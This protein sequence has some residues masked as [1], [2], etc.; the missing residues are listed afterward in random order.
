MSKEVILTI[1]NVRIK[2]YDN[3]NIVIERYEPVYNP[4]TKETN[5]KWRF[6]GYSDTFLKALKYIS[7]KELLIDF[8]AVS[9]LKSYLKQVQESNEKLLKLAEVEHD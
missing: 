1:D 4:T 3:L 7:N 9:D 6:K 8:N 5:H 2:E